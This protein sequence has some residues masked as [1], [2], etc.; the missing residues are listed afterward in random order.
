[1]RN[2]LLHTLAID[3]N[4]ILGILF[5][6]EDREHF[7]ALGRWFIALYRANQTTTLPEAEVTNAVPYL[8]DLV[9]SPAH[10]LNIPVDAFIVGTIRY[11]RSLERYG[12]YRSCNASVLR[13]DGLHRLAEKLYFDDMHLIALLLQ[14][15][16]RAYIRMS[17]DAFSRQYFAS[18]G[19][20]LWRSKFLDTRPVSEGMP[21]IPYTLNEAGKKYEARRT[22]GTGWWRRLCDLFR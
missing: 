10:R 18:V 11:V 1:M 3:Y 4:F 22:R 8:C 9:Y 5:T 15:P 21:R 2:F 17:L 16:V 14:P 6:Q 19:P 7:A 13:D 12:E 20:M